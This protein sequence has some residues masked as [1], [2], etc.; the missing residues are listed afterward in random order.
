[1]LDLDYSSQCGKVIHCN[2]WR[3]LQELHA[4]NV[5]FLTLPA[6]VICSGVCPAKSCRCHSNESLKH[7][8]INTY[9]AHTGF[10]C[11]H[12]KLVWPTETLQ[13]W[14]VYPINSTIRCVHIVSFCHIVCTVLLWLRYKWTAWLCDIFECLPDSVHY[15]WVSKWGWSGQKSL[16]HSSAL[17]NMSGWVQ[18]LP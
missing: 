12:L 8:H 6:Y 1:M 15:V 14:P 10:L 3:L 17:P 4:R 16:V 18:M 9:K 11:L 13:L 2:T 7:K 5:Q